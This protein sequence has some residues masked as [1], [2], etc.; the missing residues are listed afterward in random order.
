MEDGVLCMYGRVC[1]WKWSC[2]EVEIQATLHRSRPSCLVCVGCPIALFNTCSQN[3]VDRTDTYITSRTVIVLSVKY[4][5]QIDYR[6][7]V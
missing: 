1:E 2:C 6:E 7:G 5:I 3:H 4:Q